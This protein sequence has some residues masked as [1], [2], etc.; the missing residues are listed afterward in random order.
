MATKD[1]KWNN[2]EITASVDAYFS[3]YQ[4]VKVG[5][6]F[7]MSQALRG[8]IKSILPRRNQGSVEQRMSNISAVLIE[9]GLPWCERFKPRTNV[10]RNVRQVIIARINQIKLNHGTMTGHEFVLDDMPEIERNG[11]DANNTEGARRLIAHYMIERNSTAAEYAKKLNM[12]ANAG[13]YRCM[14]CDEKPELRYGVRVIDAHHIKP[15]SEAEGEYQ[16]CPQ[17]FLIVCPN[18]HRAIHRLED[19]SGQALK[20]KLSRA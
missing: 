1:I 18:C 15:I 5:E 7:V 6:K 19:Y 2:E 13:H 3:I 17:D 10:G 9:M 14:V 8:L 20:A 4:R 11:C 16:V 12:D